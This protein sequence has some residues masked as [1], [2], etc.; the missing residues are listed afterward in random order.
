MSECSMESWG[1]GVDAGAVV[2]AAAAQQLLDK[3]K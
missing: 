1:D 3:N 2:D